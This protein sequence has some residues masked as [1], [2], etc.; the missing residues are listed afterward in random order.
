RNSSPLSDLTM[1]GGEGFRPF[2][3]YTLC[4][5]RYLHASELEKNGVYDRKNGVLNLR[6]VIS[7]ELDHV[8]LNP[9]TGADHIKIKGA[10][11]IQRPAHSVHP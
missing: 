6:G 1:T 8:S 3:H 7:V 4:A 10:G 9:P 11:A 2:R 5:A